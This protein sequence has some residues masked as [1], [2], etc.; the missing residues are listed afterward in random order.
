MY[1]IWAVYILACFTFINCDWCEKYEC[2]KY[3]VVEK[4]ENYEVRKYEFYKMAMTK[5]SGGMFAQ[6]RNF[7]RLF[8]F[9]G[10]ENERKQKIPMTIPVIN[11]YNMDEETK[12]P[13]TYKYGMGFFMPKAITEEVPKPSDEQIEIVPFGYAMVYTVRF[14]GWITNSKMIRLQ[15]KLHDDLKADNVEFD[16]TFIGTASYNHPL[17]LWNRHNDIFYFSSKKV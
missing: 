5:S 11:F 10:G 14:G 3:E 2:A 15:R 13:D 17:E 9:I 16:E 4:K 8:K 1:S 7:M 12:K 6:Y